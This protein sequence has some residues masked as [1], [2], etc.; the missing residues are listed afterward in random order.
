M[1]DS[2]RDSNIPKSA[3]LTSSGNTRLEPY[4]CSLSL[5][6]TFSSAFPAAMA[7]TLALRTSAR[8]GWAALGIGALPNSKARV[9]TLPP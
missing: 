1:T 2:R 9:V 8:N 4:F 3:E 7:W 5:T 6:S